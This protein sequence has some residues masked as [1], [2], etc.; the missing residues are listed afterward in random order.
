MDDALNGQWSLI[1]GVSAGMGRSAALAL[2]AAGCNIAGVHIDTS[3]RQ[4]EIDQLV[5]ELRAL[6]VRVE[7][8]NANAASPSVREEVVAKLGKLTDGAGVRVLMHSLAFGSLVPL[9]PSPE[10]PGATAKQVDMTLNVMANSLIYWFQDLF[11]A[12]LLVEGSKVFAM[13]SAGTARF[14]SHYGPVSAAKAALESHVRQL[15]VEAAPHGISVNALRAGITLTE[16]FRRI[17]G[18]DDLS[19]R[20]RLGNPHGRLTTPEDVA[21]ALVLLSRARSSWI[22]GNVIGVD[23][24]EFLT[25]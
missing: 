13:T 5:D 9:L 3:G 22:T 15:A 12:G 10:Q 14:T 18:S 25:V 24:G 16:S 8:F 11:A 4:H 23:G 21:E 20:A 7:F 17:P 2:A 19:E 1:L 6:G